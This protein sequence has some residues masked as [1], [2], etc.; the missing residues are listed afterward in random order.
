VKGPTFDGSLNLA[1]VDGFE[2]AVG[3][4]SRF[5]FLRADFVARCI[6]MGDE[7]FSPI[8]QVGPQGGGP[9]AHDPGSWKKLVALR[10]MFTWLISAP[11]SPEALT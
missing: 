4:T 6:A 3:S 7:W 10:M 5:E 8:V 11:S 1:P 9:P 2:R